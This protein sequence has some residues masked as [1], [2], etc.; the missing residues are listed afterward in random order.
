MKKLILKWLGIETNR[1]G[2]LRTVLPDDEHGFTP[3]FRIGLIKTMNGGNVLEIG[4]YKPSQRGSDWT[5]EF[6]SVD[7]N[8]KLSEAVAIILTM[9]GLEK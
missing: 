1:Y 7:S 4:T 3:N 5:Y 9:K 8:Q 6:Y 2:E